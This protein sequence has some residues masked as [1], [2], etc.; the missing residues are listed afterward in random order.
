MDRC[1]VCRGTSMAV[2]DDRVLFPL[3]IDDFEYC[4]KDLMPF[5]KISGNFPTFDKQASIRNGNDASSSDSDMPIVR[6]L[7]QW[8]I[9]QLINLL[10]PGDACIHHRIRPPLI[11]I[12]VCRLFGAKPLSEPMQDYFQLDTCKHISVK[13]STKYNSFHSIKCVWKSCLQNGG[14][15]TRSQCIKMRAGARSFVVTRQG[16]YSTRVIAQLWPLGDIA[17]WLKRMMVWR[18]RTGSSHWVAMLGH[19]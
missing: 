16:W 5:K 13:S 10:R 6:L 12:M 4:I 15:L 2:S 14:H 17:C 1:C 3:A 8:P 11:Q 19:W 18:L 7:S 9:I